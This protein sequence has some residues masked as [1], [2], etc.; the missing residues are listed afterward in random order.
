MKAD[1]ALKEFDADL[2]QAQG[3]ASL[4]LY[5]YMQCLTV[6]CVHGGLASYLGGWQRPLGDRRGEAWRNLDGALARYAWVKTRD[7]EK[8]DAFERALREALECRPID[9]GR[10]RKEAKARQ[11]KASEQF[12]SA[13]E[14]F[15]W[16]RHFTV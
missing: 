13:L 5:N 1:D 3:P 7:S 16:S 11:T 14:A 4:V 6:Q 8:S 9:R 2:A 10:S 12:R 15:G